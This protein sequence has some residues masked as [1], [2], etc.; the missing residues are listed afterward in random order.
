MQFNPGILANQIINTAAKKTEEAPDNQAV[1][2]LITGF[3]V[4]FLVLLLLIGI[5]KLYSGIV[6]AAQNKAEKAKNK[7]IQTESEKVQPIASDPPATNVS[8]DTLDLQTVAVITAAVEA[9]YSNGK[10]VR[11]A[12]IR[13]VNN[14][15]NEW[16]SAGLA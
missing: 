6:N 10:K 4:V 5:I 1:I 3:V 7:K 2:I 14:Q 8:D 12:G 11:V 16:A 9:Y 13:P 15:K